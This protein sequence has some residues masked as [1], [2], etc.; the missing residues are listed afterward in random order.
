MS[1][2]KFFFV[3]V[4]WRYA[5]GVPIVAQEFHLHVRSCN[6]KAIYVNPCILYQFRSRKKN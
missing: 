2:V 3:N 6:I 1:Y 4:T 5:Q